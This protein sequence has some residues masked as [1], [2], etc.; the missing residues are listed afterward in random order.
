MCGRSIARA[1][2]VFCTC[3]HGVFVLDFERSEFWTLNWGGWMGV[4]VHVVGT[5]GRNFHSSAATECS[6]CRSVVLSAGKLWN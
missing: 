4:E 1:S 2:G 3:Q 6:S 5:S